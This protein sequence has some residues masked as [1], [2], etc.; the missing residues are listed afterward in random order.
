MQFVGGLNRTEVI[1]LLVI[2]I[3]DRVRE[4]SLSAL[5]DRIQREQNIGPAYKEL[6]VH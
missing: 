1:L 6:I 4:N 3:E 5:M 2:L